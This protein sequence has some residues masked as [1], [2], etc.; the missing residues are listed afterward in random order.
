MSSYLEHQ[1]WVS[2]IKKIVTSAKALMSLLILGLS[3][4]ALM[5]DKLDGVSFSVVIGTV[6]SI[7]MTTHMMVNRQALQA[8][9]TLQNVVSEIKKVI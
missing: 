7:F 4:T 6:G 9:S 1:T 5:F 3:F 2:G 8:S